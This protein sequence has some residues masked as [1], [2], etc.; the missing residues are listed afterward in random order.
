MIRRGFDGFVV[1]DSCLSA[2]VYPA[3]EGYLGIFPNLLLEFIPKSGDPCRAG[4]ELG[5]RGFRCSLCPPA[6]SSQA[7]PNKQRAEDR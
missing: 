7:S 1:A 3:E 2:I 5:D 6:V 4:Q